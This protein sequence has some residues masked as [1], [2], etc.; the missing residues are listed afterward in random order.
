MTINEN[1]RQAIMY[2]LGVKDGV[3]PYY[4]YY[5]RKTYLPLKNPKLIKG[6]FWL[7]D[8]YILNKY[9]LQELINM[10]LDIIQAGDQADCPG[11]QR[12]QLVIYMNMEHAN[13]SLTKV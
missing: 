7:P 12:P 13:T 11:D 6:A 5:S 9:T 8:K 4:E 1:L 3:E 10:G 2:V